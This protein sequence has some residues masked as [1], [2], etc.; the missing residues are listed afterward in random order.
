[1]KKKLIEVKEKGEQYKNNELKKIIIFLFINYNK[2]IKIFISI[3][4]YMFWNIS[5]Q[6]IKKIKK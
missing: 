4:Q 3:F 6:K 2:K 1:M 5:Y